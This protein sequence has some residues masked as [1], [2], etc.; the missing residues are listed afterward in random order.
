MSD[1]VFD[2]GKNTLKPGAQDKLTRVA[3]ILADHPSLKIQVEGHAD[4]VGSEDT[5]QA[6]SERRAEAVKDYLVKQ[7]VPAPSI[8]ARGFGE[9]RAVASNDT[10]EGRQRNRRVEVIVSGEMIGTTTT[11]SQLTH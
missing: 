1:V 2:T 4:S 9:S 7:G 3:V 5:N 10:P 11:T 8:T 6:L